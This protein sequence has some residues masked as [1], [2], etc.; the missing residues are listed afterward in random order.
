[1]F[2]WGGEIVATDSGLMVVLECWSGEVKCIC[3]LW[4]GLQT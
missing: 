1:M 3:R 2:P 4:R